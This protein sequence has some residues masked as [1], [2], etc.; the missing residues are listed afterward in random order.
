MWCLSPWIVII[1]LTVSNFKLLEFFQ[2]DALILESFQINAQKSMELSM[3][4]VYFFVKLI[5]FI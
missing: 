4:L 1:I 2:I 5:K 3:L